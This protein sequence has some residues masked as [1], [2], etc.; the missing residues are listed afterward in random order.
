MLVGCAVA[1]LPVLA[2]GA[3]HG[4]EGSPCPPS[5]DTIV[6]LARSRELFLCAGGS[7]R[8]QFAVALGRSGVGKRR[9]G[10]GR[11]P[12]GTYRLGAPRRSER[13]GTFIPIAYPTRA[14]TAR[15]F[16]GAAVGIH[17]PPRGMDDSTYPVTALDWTLG[18][19]ATGSDIDV[20]AI[21]DF[22]RA[23]RPSVVIR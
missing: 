11:T 12:L 3:T 23:R 14:Q 17:G 22:V 15:G 21:A 2:R 19:I 7:P 10:D 13:Y 8:A 6:V 18:C 1:I 20:D 16:T 4:M 5:G 9:R